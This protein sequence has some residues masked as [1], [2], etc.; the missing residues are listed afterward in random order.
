[1]RVFC[2]AGASST[3]DVDVDAEMVRTDREAQKELDKARIED[4]QVIK[5]L[6]L[7]AG[8]SGKSTIFKQMKILNKD[9][10]SVEE[11]KGFTTIV[12]ANTVQAMQM[13]LDGIE[14]LQIAVSADLATMQTSWAAAPGVS[15][16]LGRD[17]RDDRMTPET[18]ELIG[19]LWEHAAVQEAYLRKNEF[20]LIDSAQYFLTDAARIA[21]PG[22]VP[23]IQDVLRSRVRTTGIVQSDF[24]VQ[25]G[26]QR[27]QISMFDVGGQRNERRK[28]IHM[29]DN[30]NAVV[31]VAALSEYDQVRVPPPS[32]QQ[33][34]RGDVAAERA[35]APPALER[36]PA[37][38]G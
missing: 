6:L 18:G 5:L 37:P 14:K 17:L 36:A 16:G 28:W 19:K 1:M 38:S 29:F 31:F 34:R 35:H 15:G 12:H 8:E 30:V 26:R 11:R 33:A 13:L 21:R 27:T 24:F 22:Y 7:G 3:G 4:E 2:C 25:R 32:P 23:S 10:Y 20:Q 9:G